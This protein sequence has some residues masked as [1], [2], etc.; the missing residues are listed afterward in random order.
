MGTKRHK[1]KGGGELIKRKEK[2]R[3][4]YEGSYTAQ[5]LR[6]ENFRRFMVGLIVR[7]ELPEAGVDLSDDKDVN[8]YYYY[9]CNGVD[10]IHTASIGQDYVD[11]ILALVPGNLRERFPDFTAN[12][13]AEIKED[14]TR[15]MKKAVVKFALANP[16]EDYLSEVFFLSRR[17]MENIKL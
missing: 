5:R 9:I 3:K 11:A 6:Q 10:T 1:R 13:V 16:F 8:R 2:A 17:T 7:P 14:F 4:L 15:N 12:L